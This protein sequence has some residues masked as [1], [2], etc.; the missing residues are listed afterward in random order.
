MRKFSIHKFLSI[1]FPIQIGLV[2]WASRHPEWIE[3]Y[4]SQKIYYHYSLLSRSIFHKIPFSVGDVCYLALAIYIFFSIWKVFS[5]RYFSIYKLG[6]FCSIIYFLFYFNWGLNYYRQPI[7]KQLGFSN[8]KYTLTEL[9]NLTESLI[10][11]ANTSHIKIVKKDSI[12]IN[13]HF[14]EE[15]LQ[16]F[17][18]KSYEQLF[19]KHAVLTSYKI[20]YKNSLFSTALSYAGFSGYLNPFTGEAQVNSTIPKNT[21]P[22]TS[23]HE[24]AHQMGIAFENEANFLAY[25][26]T[27]NS[28][29]I[30]YQYAGYT[31]ALSYCLNNLRKNRYQKYPEII[32]KVN[33]GIIK[34]WKKQNNH[35]K[36]YQ[37]TSQ[38]YFSKTYDTFLKINQQN[39]GITSYGKVVGLVINY[40]KSVL[41]KK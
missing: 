13:I 21:K 2:F 40:E 6:A 31:F 41:H 8:K 27:T 3:N 12:A 15:E 24:M 35:W 23:C 36:A 19:K 17:S 30:Y 1:L 18:Q 38:A 29:N 32:K 28:K 25:L 5:E 7:E 20:S 14:S 22:T 26:A 37:N 9:V 33:K 34:D 16:N 10:K 4:Y 39:D 11:K